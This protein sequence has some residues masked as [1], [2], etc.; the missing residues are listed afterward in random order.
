MA[1]DRNKRLQAAVDAVRS[2]QMTLGR[3]AERFD[4]PKSTIRDHS[5]GGYSRYGAGRPT[6]LTELEEKS[7]VRSCQELAELGFGVDRCMVTKVIYNY[8]ASQRQDNPFTD[9]IPGKK[10]WQGFLR[11]WPDLSERKPQ[12]FPANRANAS[13][14][15]V[16]DHYFENVKVI[17]IMSEPV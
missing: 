10:W 12:H 1:S 2:K 11:R 13:S 4:L 6:V 15:Q 14:P 8:L 3:A 16:M 5:S 17:I 7:I 9:G